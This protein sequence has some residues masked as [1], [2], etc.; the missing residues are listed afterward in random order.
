MSRDND[1]N[2][3]LREEHQEQEEHR[4]ELRDDVLDES[5]GGV[6]DFGSQDERRK[7][8]RGRL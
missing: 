3:E 5:G 1:K 4:Q 6:D 2:D 7:E 8:G